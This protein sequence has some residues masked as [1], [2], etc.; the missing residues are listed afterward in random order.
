MII[1][2]YS[3]RWNVEVNSQ[4]KVCE[5]Q[6]TVTAMLS[7][8]DA[9]L[10]NEM[11][12]AQSQWAAVREANE[13]LV[14]T[15]FPTEINTIASFYQY[16]DAQFNFSYVFLKATLKMECE[17]PTSTLA[18]PEYWCVIH[19]AKEMKNCTHYKSLDKMIGVMINN[20]SGYQTEALKCDTLVIETAL[21]PSKQLFFKKCHSAKVPRVCRLLEQE[22]LEKRNT[23]K[24]EESTK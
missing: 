24:N 10:F 13:V 22:F 6:D 12:I 3:I 4:Q 17:G 11:C 23:F 18:L 14:V 16:V 15:F 7:S 5:T 9:H 8:A 2:G 21:N 1:L 20:L 19:R